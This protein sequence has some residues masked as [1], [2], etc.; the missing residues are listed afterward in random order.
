MELLFNSMQLSIN[1]SSQFSKLSS[2]V[3]GE[4]RQNMPYLYNFPSKKAIGPYVNSKQTQL[5]I[6]EKPIIKSKSRSKSRKSSKFSQF[7]V[8]IKNIRWRQQATVLVIGVFILC[9]GL[10]YNSNNTASNIYNVEYS[11]NFEM[12]YGDNNA[13]LDFNVSSSAPKGNFIIFQDSEMILSDSISSITNIQLALTD[14]SVGDHLVQLQLMDNKGNVISYDSHVSVLLPEPTINLEFESSISSTS[15]VMFVSEISTPCKD[16]TVEYRIFNQTGDIVLCEIIPVTEQFQYID[17]STIGGGLYTCEAIYSDELDIQIVVQQDFEILS[18]PGHTYQK[19]DSLI[20]HISPHESWQDS[21][22]R[23]YTQI[24]SHNIDNPLD[25]SAII[26]FIEIAVLLGIVVGII[27]HVQRIKPQSNVN[28]SSKSHF[29]KKRALVKTLICLG[30][31]GLNTQIFS[32]LVSGNTVPSG[33]YLESNNG[34]EAGITGNINGSFVIRINDR[35]IL[36]WNTQTAGNNVIAIKN[37]NHSSILSFRSYFE[38]GWHTWEVLIDPID[39]AT[40]ESGYENVSASEVLRSFLPDRRYYAEVNSYSEGPL[41]ALLSSTGETPFDV[42]RARSKFIFTQD[43]GL[44]RG[45]QV[46]DFADL[47]V[48]PYFEIIYEAKLVDFYNENILIDDAHVILYEVNDFNGG[49]DYKGFNFTDNSGK[50]QYS[51]NVQSYSHD[52][53]AQFY[54]RGNSLYE[55]CDQL[56]ILDDDHVYNPLDYSGIFIPDGFS[57]GSEILDTEFLQSLT[58]LR[59]EYSWFNVSSN[60]GF[61]YTDSTFENPLPIYSAS[62]QNGMLY[63]GTVSGVDGQ[64]TIQSP[65]IYYYG[66]GVKNATLGVKFSTLYEQNDFPDVLPENVFDIRVILMDENSEIIDNQSLYSGNFENHQFLNI[67]FP[68]PSLLITRSL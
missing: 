53:V 66:D 4:S 44:D 30:L 51:E 8:F 1:E 49:L 32:M 54:F 25:Q 6:I 22:T 5:D 36:N 52:L 64:A 11:S 68:S 33:L 13:V 26:S 21:E 15:F 16:A 3:L 62:A 60:Q 38:P 20:S 61:I 42:I 9:A 28:I 18:I 55:A 41:P 57:N 29:S 31:M 24:I 46:L 37:E 34:I 67:S 7:N 12:V 39:I 14:L 63:F 56:D 50:F 10:I 17:L 65:S 59:A 27:G 19:I 35:L 40:I 2:E 47:P 45:I 48:D 43:F 58:E 23:A